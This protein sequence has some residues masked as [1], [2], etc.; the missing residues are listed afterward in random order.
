M[1]DDPVTL[2]EEY[3]VRVARGER[4][5]VREYLDRA[6]PARSELARLL[7]RFLADRPPRAPDPQT[8]ATLQAWIA[9]EPTLLELRRRRR[10]RREDVVAALLARLGLDAAKR[11]KVAG[12]YHELESGLLDTSRVDRRV[13]DALAQA[14]HTPVRDLLAWPGRPGADAAPAY[15]RAEPAASAPPPPAGVPAASGA[16]SVTPEWDEVD[17]LFLGPRG[18]SS[19]R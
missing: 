8:V 5:D 19:Q 18:S 4:P 17:E 6:G 13:F 2:F 11:E 3:A 1:A 15:Y 9:G 12:Y 7:D 14:L 10:L 16:P